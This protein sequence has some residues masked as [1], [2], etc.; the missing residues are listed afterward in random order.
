MPV[1]GDMPLARRTSSW[2]TAYSTRLI[3]VRRP[4]MAKGPNGGPVRTRS[5]TAVVARSLLLG[6]EP[7]G[8]AAEGRDRVTEQDAGTGEQVALPE[9]QVG[10]Q[11]EGG[12]ALA[13]RRGVGAE[14]VEPL[15]QLHPLAGVEGRRSVV[16][17]I[18]LGH[19]PEVR[20]GPWPKPPPCRSTSTPC[21]QVVITTDRGEI[22]MELDP[23][24]APVDG[25]QLRRP[26]PQRV[27]RRAH[28]PPGRARLRDPGRR[29]RGHRPRRPRLPLRRRAR[30]GRVHRS[31][32]WPWPTPGPTPTAAS[33]SS[34]STT[35][36]ASS[37]RATTCS[38]TSPTASRSPRPS[39]SAT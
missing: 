31:A 11:V 1:R 9:R 10:G 21:Y 6:H 38:A 7:V 39:R 3:W 33:S 30:A 13:Q 32:P 28:L 26:G 2:W 18:A 19:G 25:Q 17:G 34:A 27:L 22:T 29:P 14:L 12:P 5:T 23:Q 8:E 36:A 15:A 4:G 37:R 16:A 24:L 20:V 35:A